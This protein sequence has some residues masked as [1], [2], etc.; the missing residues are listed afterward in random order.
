[1][2]KF[3]DRIWIDGIEYDHNL[4][5]KI[6]FGLESL[7]SRSASSMVLGRVED[8]DAYLEIERVG[9]L[10]VVRGSED[11]IQRGT[12]GFCLYRSEEPDSYVDTREGPFPRYGATPSFDYLVEIA[13]TY[14]ESGDI[15]RKTNW[16][17]GSNGLGVSKTHIRP[18]LVLE[19]GDTRPLEVFAKGGDV[20]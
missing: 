9:D 15:P 1:M 6:E 18:E 12:F 20:R 14:Y 16:L 11:S 19:T 13:R 8:R 4:D 17:V 10:F 5:L 7:R 2:N 3:V